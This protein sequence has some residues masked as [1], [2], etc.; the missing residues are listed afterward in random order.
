MQITCMHIHLYYTLSLSLSLSHTHTHTHTH[1]YTH[2]HTQEMASIT[3]AH[4][5][6]FLIPDGIMMLLLHDYTT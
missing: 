2:T 1:I 3:V 5:P 4:S 6:Q